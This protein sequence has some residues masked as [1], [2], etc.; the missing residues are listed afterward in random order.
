MAFSASCECMPLGLS[1]A[2][3]AAIN[4]GSLLLKPDIVCLIRIVCRAKVLEELQLKYETD[5]FTKMSFIQRRQVYRRVNYFLSKEQVNFP[6]NLEITFVQEGFQELKKFEECFK[7]HLSYS[8]QLLQS[9]EPIPK[10]IQKLLQN[11]SCSAGQQ[12]PGS[13]SSLIF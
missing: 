3:F 1:V 6:I 5:F 2:C 9:L 10:C 11:A 8:K 4:L 12:E 13:L 7:K